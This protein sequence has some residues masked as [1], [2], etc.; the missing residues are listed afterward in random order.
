VHLVTREKEKRGT[1]ASAKNRNARSQVGLERNEEVCADGVIPKKKRKLTETREVVD[2]HLF[3]K[4]KEKRTKR[5]DPVS[6][7]KRSA[8]PGNHSRGAGTC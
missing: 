7:K 1:D 6:G 8:R 5:E 3:D 2:Q 4:W